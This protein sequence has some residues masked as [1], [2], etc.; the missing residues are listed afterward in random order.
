MH[1]ALI[2]DLF[3]RKIVGFDVSDSLSVEGAL[4]ACKMAIK[5]VRN[6][7][8]LIHHSDR[9]IQYCCNAY[10]ELLDSHGVKLSMTQ[11]GNVYQ[12]AIAER[13]NGILKIDFLL[14]QTFGS[15]QHATASVK[16]SVSIYNNERPHLSLGY[17]TPE[18]V[19]QKNSKQLAL[20]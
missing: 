18:A 8:A 14:N 7:D 13:V 16:Q 10:T 20:N 2:T 3:S 6:P 19:Y 5:P 4:R 11:N 17:Q 9:G 15:I 12:N 1:L